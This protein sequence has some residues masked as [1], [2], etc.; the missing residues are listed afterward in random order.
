MEEIDFSDM[1]KAYLDCRKYKK[2]KLDAMEFELNLFSE[3][4][5]LIIEIQERRYV[6]SPAKCFITLNPS[7]REVFWA[8][9]R[10]RVVQ[11]FIYN[12]LNPIIE[13]ELI[14]DTA[15]CRKNKGV[16]FAISR[17]ARF[18]RTATDNY[19]HDVYFLKMDLRG[20]FMSINRHLL[21]DRLLDLIDRKYKGKYKETLQYLL[22]IILLTDVTKDAV[23]IS[24]SWMWDFLPKRKT[25]FDNDKGLPIG[26]ICSQLF[27][28]YELSDIDHLIK[29]RHKFY[30]RYVDDLGVFDT[31]RDK[32]IETLGLVKDKLLDIGLNL[33]L[34][35]CFIKSAKY[36]IEFLGVMIHPFYNN[37]SDRRKGRMFRPFDTENL[38]SSINGR[39]GYLRRYHGFGICKRWY[40][41]FDSEIKSHFIFNN[42]KFVFKEV[43]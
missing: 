3:L 11:H 39:M 2:D 38:L 5:D 6:L 21:L 16:D 32:L 10:D 28:N 34:N 23:I 22:P 25:L 40:E 35:K 33:N 9:F 17:M 41:T 26:N 14:F 30:E 12:E 24:P 15:S 42:L 43:M 18:L 31:D 29:S 36:G 13:K 27:G 8:A 4:L 19:T 20:Y 37:L 7:P 1:Y